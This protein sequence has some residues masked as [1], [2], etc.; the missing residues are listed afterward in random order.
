MEGEGEDYNP[1]KPEEIENEMEGFMDDERD[2]IDFS[3][4]EEDSDEEKFVERQFNYASE[5]SILVD[6]K[7]IEKY[8]LLIAQ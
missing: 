7:I 6:Y 2:M 5:I 4:S 1:K 3:G 8:V